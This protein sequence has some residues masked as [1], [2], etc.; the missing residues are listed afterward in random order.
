[1]QGVEHLSDAQKQAVWAR[2]KKAAPDL[3]EAI[4][5][6]I[7]RKGRDIDQSALS[8]EAR[9]Y[10]AGLV[11]RWAPDA[12]GDTLSNDPVIR[13]LCETFG[14]TVHTDRSV[15]WQEVVNWVALDIRMERGKEG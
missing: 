10:L 5:R 11:G 3:P 12:G 7:I 14:A 8:E 4:R 9:I 2:L 6:I 13:E 15:T 1:M